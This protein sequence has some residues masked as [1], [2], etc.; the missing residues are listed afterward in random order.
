MFLVIVAVILFI[1]IAVLV[2]ETLPYKYYEKELQ[3]KYPNQTNPFPKPV[4]LLPWKPLEFF[5]MP[6]LIVV[7]LA[8]GFAFL[9]L[10]VLLIVLPLEVNFFRLRK[11]NYF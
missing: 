8:S 9:A 7:T 5:K 1:M 6:A 4:F 11:I 10:Y 3:S 2:P